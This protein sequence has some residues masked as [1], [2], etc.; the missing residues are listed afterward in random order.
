MF[1]GESWLTYIPNYKVIKQYIIRGVDDND[2]AE[3]LTHIRPLRIGTYFELPL[4]KL[5]A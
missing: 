4:L 5:F 2:S 3:L 1:Q